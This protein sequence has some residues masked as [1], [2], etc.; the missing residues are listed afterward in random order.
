MRKSV[1]FSIALSVSVLCSGA[2]AAPRGAARAQNNN[3]SVAANQNAARATT[4]G[5]TKKATTAARAG[6]TQAV[7]NNVVSARAGSTQ[8][9]INVGTKVASA[10]ENTNVPQECQD[11]FYGCMDA[12]CMLDNASGGRCQCS[13]RVT[14]LDEVLADILKLDEQTYLMA[15]EGVERIQMGEGAEQIMA[16]AKA[17]GDKAV[18]DS[19]KNSEENKKKAR[20]LDLSAWNNTIF[21]EVDDLFEEDND[22]INNFAD[23]KGNDLYKASGKMCAA[24]ISA[25]CKSYASMMQLIYAQ[26]IK[27]DC[28]AYENSL[29]AQKNQSQQKLQTA[30]KALRDAALEEYQN[31]NKYAT[32]G[33]CAVAFARCMQTTAE[34]GTDYTGCVTLAAAENVKNNKSGSKAKQTKIKGAVSGAD[35]TLAATT[36][37]QL[38]AKKEICASVTKQCV[39]ANRNDAVWTVFL[40][41]AAP[42][43]K[44]AE[45]I[46]EQN[47]RSNC[48]PTVAKCFSDACKSQFGDNE[49]S[50]DMCL[51]DPSTYKSLCKVQLEPCLEATGG[52]FE[53]AENSSLW[54]GLV[55]MLNSMKVDACT[56]Q[57]KTCITDRCGADYAGCVGLDTET[58]GGLCPVDKL[59]ACVSGG[60]FSR[61]S[62]DG[63]ANQANVK[64]IREYVA[65]IAQGLAL[66]IDNSLA[67]ICQN[68]ATQ[69]VTAVCGDTESCEALNV[70]KNLGSSTLEY[71]VCQIISGVDAD[72]NPTITV[73]NAA[74]KD[75]AALITKDEMGLATL[76]ASQ[77]QQISR[78]YENIKKR[79]FF[80][81]FGLASVP[82]VSANIGTERQKIQRDIRYISVPNYTLQAGE[83][84]M[85]SPLVSGTI[86]WGAD[87]VIK[88]GADGKPVFACANVTDSTTGECADANLIPVIEG[89]NNA[90]NRTMA[91]I[92]SDT[93]IAYCT[94]GRELQ[95]FDKRNFIAK[96]KSNSSNSTAAR[97]NSN[98]NEQEP[99]FPNL[100]DNARRTIMDE[101]YAAAVS[102]YNDKLNELNAQRDKDYL[103]ISTKY[104]EVAA[105]NKEK[106]LQQRLATNCA[107]LRYDNSNWDYKEVLTTV[108]SESAKTCTKTL[109][110]TKC[111]KPKVGKKECKKWEDPVVTTTV[112]N[113]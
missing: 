86:D 113:M 45:L 91:S 97:R 47:L 40:R 59:T 106:E 71:K 62:T 75:S 19:K 103:A 89:L 44:S 102:N 67:V 100:L 14:E 82:L 32:A 41:N 101:L 30:Q 93:K 80:V 46:A 38:L 112:I 34:C 16:R 90:L 88:D 77:S 76:T 1:F 23:K 24:Q 2:F 52:T 18:E 15:T 72:G 63:K 81:G 92:E 107:S 33:E 58:I 53:N 20:T 73:N 85:Y 29:K 50:Y 13:D 110:I 10:T 98:S 49:E 26:K 22:S 3:A 28:V 39:N 54:N 21:N 6:K 66:Q 99:R 105:E 108:Y 78:V 60:R 84:S 83:V 95:G 42:A 36:M 31:Q 70:D 25:E 65:E 9:V 12:F 56:N 7:K 48:I 74:C 68:A 96:K 104:E 51:A 94:T 37:E 35:I 5:T 55:A 64:E 111:K 17:A 69:A 61:N 87:V 11:A 43:L 27:S 4:K 8:K 57:V 79:R 109:S